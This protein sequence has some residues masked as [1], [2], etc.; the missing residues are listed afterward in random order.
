MLSVLAHLTTNSLPPV[1][2]MLAVSKGSFKL[3]MMLYLF[4]PVILTGNG[5][6]LFLRN[7]IAPPNCLAAFDKAIRSSIRI[8][9]NL[10]KYFLS[11]LFF[12]QS[13]LIRLIVTTLVIANI[14]KSSTSSWNTSGFSFT[15]NNVVDCYRS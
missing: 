12:L 2:S 15:I 1:I 9:S 8:I 14:F 11:S 6:C 4:K 7:I 3:Y 13:Y 5:K 10:F